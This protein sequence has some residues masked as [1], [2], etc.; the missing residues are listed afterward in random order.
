MALHQ[1]GRLDQAEQEYAA[2]LRQVPRHPRALRLRGVLARERGAIDD[3]LKW[4]RAAMEAAPD[5]AEPL[6]E[7]AMTHMAAGELVLAETALRRA[8]A[9]D[10]NSLKALANLGALLQ[11]RGHIRECIDW[12]R[13]ALELDVSDVE[14]AC[15]LAKALVEAS[16]G[17]AALATCEVA[18]DI[19]P[20]DPLVLAARGAVL[21]DLGRYDEALAVL[22]QSLLRR[23][24][25]DMALVN[26]AYARQRLGQVT[27]AI[28][29]LRAALAAS[30]DNAR[31][32][33]DLANALAG[34]GRLEEALGICERFLSRHP[35]ER[36]VLAAYGFALA[37]A[38]QDAEA[39]ALFDYQRLACVV[40]VGGA[41]QGFA[42]L[43]EFNRALAGLMQSDPSLL[44]SPPSKATRGGSQTGELDLD[45]DAALRAWRGMINAAL[46][47]V[48]AEY[49]ETGLG[50]HPAMANAAGRWMLRAWGT[51]LQSGGAQAAHIHPLGWL[52]GVYYAQL[53]PGMGASGAEAG[54]LEFGTPPDRYL[55][56]RAPEP[57]RVEPREG[58]LVIFP[59]YFH[60]R[61]L[62]F[63]CAGARISIA[64]DAVP[65][66]A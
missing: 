40:D 6:C 38:G 43:A 23:P 15:N 41:P 13:R 31:A 35:G 14:V 34:T 28:A 66:R 25:D 56:R 57:R 20:G 42:S 27:P 49:R 3:S 50:Q 11:Y 58:R 2:F 48:A 64:F 21:C 52:S 10:G 29:A 54:W 37:D 33:A 61:T 30:P 60:H 39:A 36:M 55:V 51:I 16:Q 8:V 17:E 19:S 12:H 46:A 1:Q 53:P 9:R 18:L 65:L 5:D 24:G 63:D 45:R 7:L 22:E 26:L 44:Q 62:P 32:A 47:Q 59:S 4:L